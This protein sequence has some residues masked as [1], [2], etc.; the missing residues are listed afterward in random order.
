[1]HHEATLLHIGTDRVRVCTHLMVVMFHET[2]GSPQLHLFEEGRRLHLSR[3]TGHLAAT[4]G[5]FHTR[6]GVSP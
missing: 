4:G 2:W 6:I 3:Q 5:I 1:M